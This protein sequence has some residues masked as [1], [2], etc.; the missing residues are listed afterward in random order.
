MRTLFIL[1]LLL[2]ISQIG[3]AKF[4]SRKLID[5]DDSTAVKK[6]ESNEVISGRLNTRFI[7][8]DQDN[9]YG[10]YYFDSL[11]SNI[12]TLI[13]N[14]VSFNIQKEKWL[15]K[16]LEKHQKH[17]LYFQKS[18]TP[19]VYKLVGYST[20]KNHFRLLEKY[21]TLKKVELK[22]FS[23]I[24]KDSIEEGLYTVGR[25]LDFNSNSIYD[26]LDQ[27]H[28]T[29]IYPVDLKIESMWLIGGVYNLN[30]PITIELLIQ[31]YNLNTTQIVVKKEGDI[32][33][34]VGYRKHS[35]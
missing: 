13:C 25:G 8:W 15:H 7:S 16:W 10:K 35:N 5:L 6:I 1:L 24:N 21:K 3:I 4:S 28:I 23:E 11:N 31:L 14:G 18:K 12:T 19:G 2:S 30:A 34:I 20:K 27:S 26:Y 32:Y 29:L 9:N 22:D 33:T 17:W